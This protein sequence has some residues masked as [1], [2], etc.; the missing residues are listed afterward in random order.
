MSEVVNILFTSLACGTF[1]YVACSELVVEEFEDK[2]YKWAKYLAF[3]L[4][5]G[6]VS[7]MLLL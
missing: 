5:A 6:L 1:I 4:G 2:S 3:L 7:C